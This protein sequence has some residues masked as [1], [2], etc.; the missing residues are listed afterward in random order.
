MTSSFRNVRDTSPT[1]A[2]PIGEQQQPATDLSFEFKEIRKV[3]TA[4][5][6]AA[7]LAAL[8][9]IFAAGFS[10]YVF[11]TLIDIQ[12]AIVKAGR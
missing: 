11:L 6:V 4:T 5:L 3:Q 12:A 7:A 1:P 9:A 10:A 8:A 2:A